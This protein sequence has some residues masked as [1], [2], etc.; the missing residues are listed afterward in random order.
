MS[1]RAA[2]QVP[3]TAAS[4]AAFPQRALAAFESAPVTAGFFAAD[5][6]ALPVHG[7]APLSIQP[8]LAIGRQDDVFE[9]EADRVADHVMGAAPKK[10]HCSSCGDPKKPQLAKKETDDEPEYETPAVQTEHHGAAPAASA[11]RKSAG[12][13]AAHDDTFAPSL[14]HQVLGGG[15]RP[16]DSGVRSFMEPRF[17]R[18]FSHVRVHTGDDAARSATAIEAHAYTAGR[19]IVF[20]AGQ[21]DGASNAGRRLIAHELAHVVQQG[22]GAPTRI[23]RAINTSVTGGVK[24]SRTL[25]PCDW[26]ETWPESV[27]EWVFAVKD[28]SNWKADPT[29]LH[30]NSSQQTRLVA[31]HQEVT[32]PSGNTTKDNY[33]NQVTE[34]RQL[35]NCRTGKWYILSAVVAHEN[36]HLSRFAP[37]LKI[38][39]LDIQADFNAVT[40]PDAQGKTATSA[41]TELKALPAYATAKSQMQPHWLSS[42]GLLTRNDHNGPTSVAEHRVVDPMWQK[43]CGHAKQVQW[44]ECLACPP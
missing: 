40:V 37:A 32:G 5:F 28:G 33:C 34:L 43:I 12:D 1:Q 36:V 27:V 26:G 42:I 13:A 10:P 41:L 9:A 29:A 15:G 4:T 19:D 6:S 39:A 23:R 20:A 11:Q 21:Y 14:V 38:A 24:P 7:R 25:Q 18:D 35:G 2:I 17:G 30:G 44:P 3:A 31:N 16:L 8:K 22:S